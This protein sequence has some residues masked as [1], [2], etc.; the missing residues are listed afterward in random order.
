MDDNTTEHDTVPVSEVGIG[1]EAVTDRLATIASNFEKQHAVKSTEVK[2][3]LLAGAAH[4]RVTLKDGYTHVPEG[5]TLMVSNRAMVPINID[6]EGDGATLYVTTLPVYLVA[7]GV[8]DERPPSAKSITRAL[9]AY[10]Q[11]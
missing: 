5:V 11:E 9:E 4:I 2:S 7:S 3:D 6:W 1:D 10:E 8:V